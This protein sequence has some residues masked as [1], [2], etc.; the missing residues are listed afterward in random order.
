M[1]FSGGVTVV[2][3]VSGVTVVVL[4]FSGLLETKLTTLKP[5]SPACPPELQT[6]TVQCCC[7]AIIAD[8][9]DLQIINTLLSY[10]YYAFDNI[11]FHTDIFT[12]RIRINCLT[13]TSIVPWWITI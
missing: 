9:E 5:R 13:D 11:L 10:R 6:D 7:D 1:L 12:Q 3:L 8:S 2:L 4:V